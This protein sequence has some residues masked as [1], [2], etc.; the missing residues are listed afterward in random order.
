LDAVDL[1]SP[2]TARRLFSTV[3]WFGITVATFMADFWL[4]L[5]YGMCFIHLL[6]L[7]PYPTAC[8]PPTHPPSQYAC[9]EISAH[10]KKSVQKPLKPAF[11]D[12]QG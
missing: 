5:Y 1:K 2:T 9:P 11:M 6:P 4:R 12:S 8:P 7:P 10:L 3:E